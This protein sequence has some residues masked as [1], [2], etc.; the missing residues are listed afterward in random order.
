MRGL[1][2]P[3]RLLGVPY[4]ADAE[5]VRRA[6]RERARQ[7]HPDRGG[8]TEAFHAAR[9]A[10]DA[11]SAD[12]EGERAR[13]RPPTPAG[14]PALDRRRFPTCAVRVSRRRDGRRELAFDLSTRP[15]RW[16]PG[17]TPPPGGT[18]RETVPA[19]DGAPAFGVWTVPTGR[20]TFRCVFGPPAADPPAV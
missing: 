19:A 5:A 7:T 6:F 17:P 10:Y 14:R 8:S 3:F 4:H 1:R 11:L 18:C 20:V 9:A 12:L 13:W 16:R 2:D 15:P